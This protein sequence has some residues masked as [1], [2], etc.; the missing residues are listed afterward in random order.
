MKNVL[1]DENN[2]D[3]TWKNLS[4][5]LKMWQI[6]KKEGLGSW[7]ENNLRTQGCYEYYVPYVE[8]DILGWYLG[9]NIICFDILGCPPYFKSLVMILDLDVS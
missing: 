5:R 7:I 8:V 9:G 2:F 3:A 6:T 1:K 4:V